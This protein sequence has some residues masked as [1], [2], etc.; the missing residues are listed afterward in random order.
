VE[1]GSSKRREAQHRINLAEVLFPIGGGSGGTAGLVQRGGA[2]ES[3][4]RR[5]RGGRSTA[6]Q[7]SRAAA[8]VAWVG[9]ERAWAWVK[10]LA[11]GGFARLP[12][13]AV[14]CSRRLTFGTS[15]KA[16]HPAHQI[17][18]SAD[19]DRAPAGGPNLSPST[20]YQRLL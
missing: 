13:D 18:Y 3:G 12:N 5:R 8:A 14:C 10:F 11:V 1:R 7:R 6:R 15:D 2:L 20:L 16:K 4:V 17:F 9:R 19:A